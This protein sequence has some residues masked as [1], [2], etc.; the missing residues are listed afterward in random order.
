MAST[1]PIERFE[2]NYEPVPWS[3]CWLW[4][5]ARSGYGHGKFNANGV[6]WQ[7][8]RYSYALLVGPISDGLVLDHLCHNA[9]CVNPAHLEPVTREENSHRGGKGSWHNRKKTHCPQGHPYDLLN[10]IFSRTKEGWMRRACRECARLSAARINARNRLHH[11][12]AP[13]ASHCRNGHEYTPENTQRYD[14]ARMCLTCRR[15]RAMRY[16]RKQRAH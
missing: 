2:G 8:Y 9:L 14:G 16:V 5:G 6:P 13:E 7:A 11:P 4:T 10:T 1:K 12:P 3:G 15:S